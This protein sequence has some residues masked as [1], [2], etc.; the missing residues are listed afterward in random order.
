MGLRL[1]RLSR[2]EEEASSASTSVHVGGNISGAMQAA[3][4]SAGA[5]VVGEFSRL[6]MKASG[7]WVV[8]VESEMRAVMSAPDLGERGG[9]CGGS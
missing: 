6:T 7:S 4:R 8:A 2:A 9:E 5:Q 1:K 3:M